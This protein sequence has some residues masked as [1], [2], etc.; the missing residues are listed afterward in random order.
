M[1]NS[2]AIQLNQWYHVATTLRGTEASIYING[3]FVTNATSL[4]P[5]STDNCYSYFGVEFGYVR[6]LI[7]K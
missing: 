3:I 1:N 4:S 6:K 7:L 5:I 2:K